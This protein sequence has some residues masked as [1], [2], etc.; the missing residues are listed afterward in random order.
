MSKDSKD[1]DPKQRWELNPSWL[2]GLEPIEPLLWASGSPK[3]K[4]RELANWS[5][6]VLLSLKS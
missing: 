3:H 1:I 2:G 4:A 6:T 5:L